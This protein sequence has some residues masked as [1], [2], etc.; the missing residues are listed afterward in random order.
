MKTSFAWKEFHCKILGNHG[1]LKE[2]AGSNGCKSISMALRAQRGWDTLMGSTHCT[3]NQHS[4]KKIEW[5]GSTEPNCGSF[6]N[7]G[8]SFTST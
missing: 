5:C 8:G 1:K 4:P 7:H 6:G 2:D 3:K